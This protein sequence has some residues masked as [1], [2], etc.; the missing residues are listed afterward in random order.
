[1][2][3]SAS[4]ELMQYVA[5]ERLYSLGRPPHRDQFVLKGALKVMVWQAL[6]PRPTRDIDLLARMDNAVQDVTATM[7]DTCEVAVPG[8]ALR[9]A[10]QTVAGERSTEAADYGGVREDQRG[11]TTGCRPLTRRSRRR[12]DVGCEPRRRPEDGGVGQRS[13]TGCRNDQGR[14]TDHRA[15]TRRL[16]GLTTRG[17]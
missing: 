1:M 9:F 8:D 14:D 3:T 16:S 13:T 7:R 12:S 17:R 4:N 11:E 2:L 15:L 5:T 10:A 6:F